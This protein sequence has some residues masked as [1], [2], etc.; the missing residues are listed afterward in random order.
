MATYGTYYLNEHMIENP[1]GVYTS[2]F[3]LLITDKI[4]FDMEACTDYELKEFDKIELENIDF[5]KWYLFNSLQDIT[6]NTM[7]EIYYEPD[8]F[9]AINMLLYNEHRS[10]FYDIMDFIKETI[11]KNDLKNKTYFIDK[12]NFVFYVKIDD[13]LCALF[14][15]IDNPL[16]DIN[17]MGILFDSAIKYN[18]DKYG[19]IDKNGDIITKS[20]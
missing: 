18:C 4:L 7:R 3:T 9:N 2:I 20:K 11:N 16:A 12:Y 15:R 10:A 6:N 13:S 1:I 14:L 19:F 17:N 8:D 5:W